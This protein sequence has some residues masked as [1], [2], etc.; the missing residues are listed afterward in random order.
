MPQCNKIFIYCQILRLD[1][2]V[3]YGCRLLIVFH[4]NLQNKLKS[5]NTTL[6]EGIYGIQLEGHFKTMSNLITYKAGYSNLQSTESWENAIETNGDKSYGL[7][8]FTKKTGKTIGWIGY[9]LSWT[10]RRFDNINFGEW[11][12]YNMI[13]GMIF[14]HIV[15]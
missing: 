11:Y 13:V 4:L 1:F 9:T 6:K 8:F 10:N 3:I 15:P 7:E 14:C 5:I 2:L 12:P